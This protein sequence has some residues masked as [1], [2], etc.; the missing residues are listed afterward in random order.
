MC[1]VTNVTGFGGKRHN[2]MCHALREVPPTGLEPV[3]LASEA[4]ALSSELRGRTNHGNRKRYP[5]FCRDRHLSQARNR[6]W[7]RLA[8]CVLHTL[9]GAA[10]TGPRIAAPAKGAMG[11][12]HPPCCRGRLACAR[13]SPFAPSPVRRAFTLTRTD[14]GRSSLCCGCC[15]ASSRCALPHLLF[16]EDHMCMAVG[17]FLWRSRA[18]DGLPWLPGKV[19]CGRGDSNSHPLN[20]D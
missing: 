12:A 5:R 16:R 1:L 9:A 13:T 14:P 18:S 19:R 7:R 8:W 15:R 6:V 3:H 4:S 10:A 20:E 11:P 17:K 2:A